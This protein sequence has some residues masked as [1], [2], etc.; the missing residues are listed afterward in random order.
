M[1]SRIAVIYFA[2]KLFPSLLVGAYLLMP[3][4]P[5]RKQWKMIAVVLAVVMTG[6]SGFLWYNA[7]GAWFSTLDRFG[8]LLCDLVFTAELVLFFLAVYRCRLFPAVIFAVGGW[9]AEH[10]SHQIVAIVECL[11]LEN[12]EQ[13]QRFLV[14]L[15]CYIIVYGIL[16]FIFS[17]KRKL[18]APSVNKRMIVPAIVLFIVVSVLAV[19]NPYDIAKSAKIL[20]YAYALASCS[21]MLFLLFGAFEEGRLHQEI[22]LLN[23]LDRKRAEQYEM[24]KE[25]IEAVNTRCHDLK[26]LIEQILSDKRT[27]D[28]QAVVKELQEYDSIVQTG[29]AAFDTILTEKSLFCQKNGI[30]FTVVADTKDLE[31]LSDIDIYSL[32]GNILD[33]AIEA[34]MKLPVKERLIDLTVRTVGEMLSIHAENLFDGALVYGEGEIVTSEPNGAEHGFGLRSIRRIVKKYAGEAVIS[35]EDKIFYLDIVIPFIK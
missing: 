14:D 9:A 34:V 32:F 28:L 33:N 15:S 5:R 35:V 26:K 19:Y 31:K 12:A 30:K 20:N 4:Y 6:F 11:L 25:S 1:I 17:K 3:Q 24:S 2:C 13:W 22:D 23:Q 16:A 18:S 10:T 21:I 29:N 8:I 7:T 27:V